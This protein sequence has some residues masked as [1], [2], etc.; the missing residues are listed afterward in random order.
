[1]EHVRGMGWG[2]VQE[3]AIKRLLLSEL[4]VISWLVSDSMGDTGHQHCRV[5][6]QA[7]VTP[8]CVGTAPGRPA[9]LGAE[10]VCCS[11]AGRLPSTQKALLQEW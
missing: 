3:E 2:V 11:G 5:T 1:M 10:N 9:T 8:W 7:Q 4:S 6:S